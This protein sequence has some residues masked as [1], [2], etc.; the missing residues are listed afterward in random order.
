[1]I[2]CP[3]IYSPGNRIS[4]QLGEIKKKFKEP[5]KAFVFIN[6][7]KLKNQNLGEKV[8]YRWRRDFYWKIKK[9]EIIRKMGRENRK[10]HTETGWRMWEPEKAHE[11]EHGKTLSRRSDGKIAIQRRV[12]SGIKKV[13]IFIF[14]GIQR[15]R[16]LWLEDNRRH[17]SF[18]ICHSFPYFFFFFWIFRGFVWYN[19]K[20]WLGHF[21]QRKE[22][23]LDNGKAG[24]KWLQFCFHGTGGCSFPYKERTFYMGLG[25]MA[26]SD[27]IYITNFVY[28]YKYKYKY[29]FYW[30]HYDFDFVKHVS[31]TLTPS[32]FTW[33]FLFSILFFFF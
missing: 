29:L 6:L 7:F 20:S 21:G 28:L 11:E 1:M 8:K 24:H 27:A 9:K 33:T 5:K 25:W 32:Q 10:P 14:W 4:F 12:N 2:F 31:K 15:E 23:C 22:G 13:H 18:F 30:L 3:K 26:N 16:A 17:I 19:G